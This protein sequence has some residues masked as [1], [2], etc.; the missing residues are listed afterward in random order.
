[1]TFSFPPSADPSQT[2]CHLIDIL[3][4]NLSESTEQFSVQLSTHVS[5]VNV[6]N[7]SIQV[8]IRDNDVVT[9]GLNETEFLV[10][11][12]AAGGA[13]VTVCAVLTGRLQKTIVVRMSTVAS[14]ANRELN[15]EKKSLGGEGGGKRCVLTLELSTLSF[16][17]NDFSAVDEV[18]SFV[19]TTVAKQTICREVMI[20]DDREVEGAEF[21]RIHLTSDDPSVILHPDSA[22]VTISEGDG[23]FQPCLYIYNEPDW[24]SNKALMLLVHSSKKINF[25]SIS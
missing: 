4:D 14:S 3:D 9:I 17:A 23:K 16:I 24:I 2:H 20:Y 15:F 13:S 8:S 7:D 1:M 10:L 6:V 18:L 5:R 19:P 11:E 21:F 12:E 25:C 22:D